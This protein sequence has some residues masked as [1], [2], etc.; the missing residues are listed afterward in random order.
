MGPEAEIVDPLRT[1]PLAPLV[2]IPAKL[3]APVEVASV[4]EV[5]L[6]LAVPITPLALLIV[7]GPS[8]VTP[9]TAPVKVTAPVPAVKAAP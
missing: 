2:V 9:P 7:R 1:I 4:K 8:L 6:M 3:F 5:A